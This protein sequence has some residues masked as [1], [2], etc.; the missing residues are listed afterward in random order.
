MRNLVA[1]VVILPWLALAAPDS[2]T[3]HFMNQPAS[4]FDLG[5]Y[6]LEAF[7]HHS[8]EFMASLYKQGAETDQKVTRRSGN[9]HARYDPADDMIYVSFSIADE[10]AT[11]QQMESGCREMLRLLRINTSK[12]I[13]RMFAHYGQE[14][15]NPDQKMV[16][17]LYDKFELRCWVHDHQGNGR[18]WS[19]MPLQG[20]FGGTSDMKIGKWKVS[21]D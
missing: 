19:T 15:D 5:M 3:Q 6:R 13:W 21:N 1:V 11:E 7:A 16:K 9:I 14:R 18:F 2:T 8:S 17:L 12:S 10:Q 4:L 20:D